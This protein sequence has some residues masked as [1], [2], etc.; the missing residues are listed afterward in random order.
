[1]NDDKMVGVLGGM[2]PAA[3]VDFF[4]Q[5]VRL[6]PAEKDW[7]HLHII[8]DNNPRMPSRSRAYLYGE[9]SP[10]PHLIAGAQRLVAAGAQLIAVP[11]NSA[12]YFLAEVRAAVPVPVLDPVAATVAVVRP[13][14]RPLVLGGAVTHGAD[15]Y[16]KHLPHR[17]RPTDAEQDEVIALIEA[18]KHLDTS[19]AI[20]A[21]V[22]ALVAAGRA[23]GADSVVLGCTEFS[24]IA[25]RV[26]GAPVFNS[27]E[28]L[29]R[30]TVALARTPAT[31]S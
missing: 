1:M 12:A 23:R 15:L 16:G 28:L 19:G 26:T 6:T 9:A 7:D 8:V 18:L 25:D 2:G 13:D 31:D 27:N 10:T 17:V 5:L 24:L 21:R 29:A 20:V 14:Q 4:G 22:E 11:C 3:T 30:Q